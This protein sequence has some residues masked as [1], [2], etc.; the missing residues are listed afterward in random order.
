MVV[1]VLVN[2]PSNISCALFFCSKFVCG[3]EADVVR[4]HLATELGRVEKLG[5][6]DANVVGELMLGFSG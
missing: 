1:V 2:K 5:A 3:A 6:A 4:V